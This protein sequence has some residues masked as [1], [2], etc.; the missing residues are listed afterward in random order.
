MADV[1]GR[2]T[3]QLEADARKVKTGVADAEKAIKAS[4]A[5]AE[6]AFGQ[7][8]TGAVS[9][10]GTSL[11]R[12]DGRLT[13]MT[14]RGGLSGAI[15]GGVGLGAG[16]SVFNTVQN[17]VSGAIAKVGQGIDLASYKAE[18][19]S[20]AN[21]LFGDSYGIVEKASRTAATSVGLSSGAYL[22]AAS[23]VA[24]LVTNFGIAGDEAANMSRDIVQLSAD[25]GSFNNAPTE[26]VVE[27]IGAA[28]RGETEPI[29]RFGVM[30]S[31][32]DVAA[33]AVAMGLASSTKAVNTEAKARATY[34]LILEQTTKAQG[35]FARTSTGLANSQR[36]ATAKQEEALTRLGEAI[37]PLYKSLF[38]L[39]TGAA[40]GFVEVLSGLASFTVPLVEG[41]LQLIGAAIDVIGDKMNDLRRF[42]DPSAALLEDTYTE[43]ARLAEMQGV[44]GNKAVEW[45]KRYREEQALLALQMDDTSI[46]AQT[47]GDRM[48]VL[49][50][51]HEQIVPIFGR[52]Q[53]AAKD[54]GLTQEQLS[55]QF[56]AYID[57]LIYAGVVTDDATESMLQ[58]LAAIA[59]WPANIDATSEGQLELYGRLRSTTGEIVRQTAAEKDA[60][61][62]WEAMLKVYPELAAG[63]KEVGAGLKE[64][65]AGVATTGAA[66]ATATQ[67][68]S[69]LEGF[70][71]DMASK[72]TPALVRGVDAA[73]I[74]FGGLGPGIREQLQSARQEVKAAM[75]DLRFMIENPNA[76]KK[77]LRGVENQLEASYR[78]QARAAAN[79]NQERVALERALQARLGGIWTELTGQAYRAGE[80]I[81]RRKGDG[82][83]KDRDRPPRIVREMVADE[84]RPLAGLENDARGYGSRTVDAYTAGLLSG[85]PFVSGAAR[86][87]AASAGGILRAESPPRHPL[88]P[89][90][91]VVLWGRRTMQSYGE[92]FEAEG[93]ATRARIARAMRPIGPG[94]IR[95]PALA[96]WSATTSQT[97]RHEHGGTVRVDLTTGAARAMREA[98]WRPADIRAVAGEMSIADLSAGLERHNRLT[99]VAYARATEV[100]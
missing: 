76:W 92:G 50:L 2:A 82:L 15:L 6:K 22:T 48:K 17:L 40:T 81:T 63:L 46:D 37:T 77:T 71:T 9:K 53:Q 5:E 12:L 74:A 90:R 96:G 21:I 99:S 60:Q 30:L 23:D 16:L 54:A 78:R 93:A 3:Y 45:A 70:F 11:E 34:A 29:R 27:A 4:G 51:T 83:A 32:A 75:A 18:A 43:V 80:R 67:P 65:G 26:Q 36:I 35:D 39:V 33:K 42:L 47:L 68:L 72:W 57:T 58:Y 84:R 14:K 95:N 61:A 91:D 73:V 86:I 66:A 64:V 25:M 38:P 44:D 10:F 49:G 59:G 100:D 20:K 13:A 97:V 85:V 98:G 87:I 7:Q 62:M 24:N 28:F 41:G 56:L 52:A 79:D 89:L 31:A 88:N 8:A 19:A 94:A 69:T 1:I 55:N